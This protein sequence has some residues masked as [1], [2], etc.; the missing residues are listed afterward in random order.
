MFDKTLKPTYFAS[1]KNSLENPN[2]LSPILVKR[3]VR[4]CFQDTI[5]RA[6]N[7]P[8]CKELSND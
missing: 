5:C 3:I 6:G 7:A 8:I 2:G 1:E 4:D